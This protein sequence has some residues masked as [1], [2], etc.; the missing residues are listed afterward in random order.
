[1]DKEKLQTEVGA[2]TTQL[3]IQES[4]LRDRADENI[5]LQK[6]LQTLSVSALC[7]STKPSRLYASTG[8]QFDID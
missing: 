3:E 1:M 2:K 8:C 6:E 4:D 7:T 5:R